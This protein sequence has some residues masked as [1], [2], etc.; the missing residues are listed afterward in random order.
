VAFLIMSVGILGILVLFPMGILSSA[1]SSN[2][3]RSAVVARSALDMLKTGGLGNAALY[4]DTKTTLPEDGPWYIPEQVSGADLLDD[5]DGL[6]ITGAKVDVDGD[7]VN[8]VIQCD[9]ATAFSWNAT[10]SKALDAS[11]NEIQGLYEIQIRVFRNYS[12]IDNPPG[13]SADFTEGDRTVTGTGTN[14]VTA[15]QLIVGQHIRCG[16]G[17]TDGLWYEIVA[18]NSNTELVLSRPYYGDGDWTAPATSSGDYV[19]SKFLIA[20]Y[21]SFVAA[22]AVSP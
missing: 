11:Y 20:V 5:G 18:I 3:S 21:D 12:V 17:D 1:R 2:L 19:V 22:R 10:V 6:V 8:D 16:A 4:A 7:T 15:R 13:T 9:E 14:W